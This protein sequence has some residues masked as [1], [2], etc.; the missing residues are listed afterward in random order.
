MSL[1]RALPAFEGEGERAFNTDGVLTDEEGR[2]QI[3]R[4]AMDQSLAIVQHEEA[5]PWVVVS[6]PAGQDRQALVLRVPLLGR[7][8]VDARS[9]SLD[10]DGFSILDPAGKRLT[11]GARR[12]RG[13][14]VGGDQWSLR[15]KELS[16][17]VMVS[18][19]ATTIVFTWRGKEVARSAVRI[20]SEEVVVIR[21]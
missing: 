4:A 13:G 9:S 5:A 2:F 15:P 14:W 21:P 18:E 12:G 7:V 3:E 6:I 1:R 8:Q 10:V 19:E 20:V 11:L 16:E 17:P